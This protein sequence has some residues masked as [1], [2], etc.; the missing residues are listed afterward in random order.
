MPK[1]VFLLLLKHLWTEG[2]TF[3]CEVELFCPLAP[4]V[5][6]E[7]GYFQKRTWKVKLWGQVP[8]HPCWP[9]T[10]QV[11]SWCHNLIPASSPFYCPEGLRLGDNLS[12]H[13]WAWCLCEPDKSSSTFP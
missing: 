10:I 12:D 4:A 11:K 9:G 3:A 1:I 6:E 7:K 13:P 8:T 2:R 5:V